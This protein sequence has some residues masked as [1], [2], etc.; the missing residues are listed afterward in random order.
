VTTVFQLSHHWHC[1]NIT[2]DKGDWLAVA[3]SNLGRNTDYPL[4]TRIEFCITPGEGRYC[5]SD[6]AKNFFSSKFSTTNHLL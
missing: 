2:A 4:R 6:Y 3:G 1:L 5:T